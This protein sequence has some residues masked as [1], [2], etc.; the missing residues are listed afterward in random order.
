MPLTAPYTHI[1]C[2][3]VDTSS[4]RST[5][6]HAS[7]LANQLTR[8]DAYIVVG[9]DNYE[10][11]ETAGEEEGEGTLDPKSA[12]ANY[13]LYPIEH[14]L[15]C[16]DCHQIRCPRCVVEEIVCWFCPSCLFEVPSSVVKGE[17]NRC[18]DG[19]NIAFIFL[20]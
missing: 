7:T 9:G 1:A 16:E 17:G 12:R 14:L 6:Q 18:E 4:S 8:A 10:D 20:V 2:P 5:H 15:Y 3:C 11:R 19:H 13:L